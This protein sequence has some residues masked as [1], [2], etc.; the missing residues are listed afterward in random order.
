VQEYTRTAPQSASTAPVKPAKRAIM[1]SP[2]WAAGK[3]L[4]TLTKFDSA[5]ATAS[6]WT[7]QATAAKLLPKSRTA[8]CMRQFQPGVD[9]VKVQY[10]AATQSSHYA[11]LIACKSVWTC[12]VC[13]A[14]ITERRRVELQQTV[15]LARLQGL[16]VVMLTYT[17]S[18]HA[19]NVLSEMMDAMRLAFKNYKGGRAAV[20]LRKAFAVIG[21]VRALEVTHS[22]E[23]GWHP[24]IHELVFLP[25]QVDVEAFSEACRRAWFDAAAA[26][27]LSMNEHGFKCDTTDSR[28][29]EYIAKWDHAPQEATMKN[30]EQ[31][32][33]ESS[34]ITKWHVK[35][36]HPVRAVDDHVTPFGLLL[37]AQMGDWQAGA[38]FVDY[39]KAFKGL[40]QLH[41][42]PGLRGLLQLG[43]ELSDAE[44]IDQQEEEAETLVEIGHSGWAV[45]LG[46]DARWELLNSAR[47][48][49]LDQVVEF[50]ELLGLSPDGGGIY[51]DAA[52]ISQYS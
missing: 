23:N 31:G 40:K 27:G 38:L 52:F 43:E 22:I 39:A 42:S 19:D 33:T 24:H 37:C 13:A 8:K 10:V 16:Q 50:L 44:L 28:I 30:W 35:K 17:F 51:Q 11:G 5:Q 29:S 12:P 46:N 49:D 45:V 48:G 9:A 36:G 2:T 7:L 21:T 25:V 15:R 26:Q 6:R 18:H 20:A 4:G 32:W 14:K 34:E 1:G 41:W 47:S 3:A